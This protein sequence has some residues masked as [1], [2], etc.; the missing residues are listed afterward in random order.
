MNRG[1]CLFKILKVTDSGGSL[2]GE[3]FPFFGGDLG[4]FS[5]VSAKVIC[6]GQSISSLERKAD[7]SFIGRE[8]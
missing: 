6:R 7:G 1:G 3:G 5:R 4:R 2:D 8:M